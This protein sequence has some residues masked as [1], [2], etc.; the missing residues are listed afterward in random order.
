ML[1]QRASFAG[2]LAL[3]LYDIV[4]GMALQSEYDAMH[5]QYLEGQQQ[6]AQLRSS[7]AAA[8]SQQA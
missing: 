5:R 7:H 2:I 3:G 4:R 6:R 8:G 1:L